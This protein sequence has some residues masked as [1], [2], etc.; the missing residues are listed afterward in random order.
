MKN[1]FDDLTKIFKKIQEG[2]LS[3]YI[4]TDKSKRYNITCKDHHLVIH[5]FDCRKKAIDFCNYLDINIIAFVTH[6]V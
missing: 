5:S 2:N 3:V 1:R 4:E 6:K